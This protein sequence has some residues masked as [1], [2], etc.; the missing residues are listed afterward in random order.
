MLIVDKDDLGANHRSIKMSIDTEAAPKR[1]NSREVDA[2]RKFGTD[3]IEAA[4]YTQEMV[5]VKIQIAFGTV[6]TAVSLNVI[7]D[8]QT[9]VVVDFA[10]RHQVNEISDPVI[11]EISVGAKPFGLMTN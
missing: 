1:R 11:K 3:V 8:L 4:E 2:I 7:R 5:Y 9:C 6:K 10:G